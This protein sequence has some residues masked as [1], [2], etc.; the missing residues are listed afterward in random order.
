MRTEFH[1]TLESLV[2]DLAEMC[3]RA[4]T[5]MRSATTALLDADLSEAEHLRVDLTELSALGTSVHDRAYH[6]LALQAPVARDLR[7]VVSALHIGADADRMGALA[8]H[9]ARTAV[10]RYPERAVPDDVSDLFTEMGATAVQLAADARDAVRARDTALAER[11]CAGD[12]R[13][14]DLHRQLFVRVVGPHWRHGPMGA[15]DVVLLGRFYERFADHAV[16]IARR[17]YF[18]ATGGQL[19]AQPVGLS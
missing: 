19:A 9:V 17:V 10:R 12:E 15:A 14:D 1:D 5:M 13:M 11:I 2:T 7:T 8:S 18:Q 3:G 4:S 16:E 6:L